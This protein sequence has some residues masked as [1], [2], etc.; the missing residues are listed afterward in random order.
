MFT[1]Q[2]AAKIMASTPQSLPIGR[3]IELWKI[4]FP[5]HDLLT[6][7]EMARQSEM[8]LYPDNG[9]RGTMCYPLFVHI[10]MLI[11]G[12]N[13]LPDIY[14]KSPYARRP[15]SCSF[16]Q[17]EL[18]GVFGARVSRNTIEEA[19]SKCCIG[20]KEGPWT[21]RPGTVFRFSNRD[22]Y[23]CHSLPEGLPQVTY[24]VYIAI[25]GSRKEP[26]PFKEIL[27]KATLS[28]CVGYSRTDVLKALTGLVQIGLV[29]VSKGKKGQRLYQLI[30]GN[31]LYELIPGNEGCQCRLI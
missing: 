23:W 12:A 13:E 9:D 25:F 24:V 18:E 8:R 26:L 15:A 22:L 2:Q 19:A 11:G 21:V 17:S 3:A 20:S 6:I 29:N 10:A 14:G 27:D 7:H 31:V 1:L 4:H 30:P 5:D 28:G 16:L